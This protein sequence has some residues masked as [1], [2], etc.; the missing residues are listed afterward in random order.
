MKNDHTRTQIN[1]ANEQGDTLSILS[2]FADDAGLY[3]AALNGEGALVRANRLCTELLD[4]EGTSPIGQSIHPDLIPDES[5]ALLKTVLTDNTPRS[6]RTF[7]HTESGGRRT[8]SWHT[9]PFSSDNDPNTA[10]VL[11]GTEITTTTTSSNADT[12]NETGQRA[13]ETLLGLLRY[14]A[15]RISDSIIIT[16]INHTIIY[17]NQATEMLFGH[18][19]SELLNRK[20]DFLNAELLGNV[21][22]Q[23]IYDN[24][25]A[26]HEWSGSVRN[27]RKDGS[28]FICEMKISPITNDDGAVIAYM[29]IQRNVTDDREARNALKQSEEKYRS[30]LENI[31][32]GYYEVDLGGNFTFFNDSMS[33]ILGYSLDDMI[34]MNNRTFMSAETARK[35]FETFNQV[36]RTSQ[37]V[38]A[39]DW[40]LIRKDKEKRFVEV[41]VSLL[42]DSKNQ[43]IGFSGIA[44][45]ITERKRLE[46]QLLEAQ[47]MEAIGTLAGGIAHDFNNI[48][49]SILGFASYLKTKSC[50]DDDLHKGLSVIEESAIRA[51][52]LTA[53]LLAYSRKGI[54]TIKSLNLNRIVKEVCESTTKGIDKSIA[55]LFD[56]Q[57]DL[58]NIRGDES[59]I[60]QVVMN[61]VINARDAMPDGGKLTIKT[62]SF[63]TDSQISMPGGPLNPGEYVLLTISDTGKGMS[64]ETLTRMFEP[65]FTTK[66][67]QDGAGLG[68]SVVYGIVKSHGGNIHVES[69]PGIGTQIKVYLP[70]THELE[71]RTKRPDPSWQG[72]SET[73]LVVDDEDSIVSML[74]QVLTNAGYSVMSTQ[75]GREGLRLYE[76]NI[77][78]IDLVILDIIMP[79]LRGDE[80]LVR[81]LELN[82]S[83]RV[84]LAS[85]YSDKESY[86]H[87]LNHGTVEFI[88]KPFTIESL[89]GLIRSIL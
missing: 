44:R 49:A 76:E 56:G 87:L 48:L 86:R 46:E 40:E 84:I 33:E 65:Y 3:F 21:I 74:T 43:P 61:L 9:A 80:A 10:L 68:M 73:I 42:Q 63:I 25:S 31:N 20:P 78:D 39:F 26:G 5:G 14:V 32:D 59:Q 8:V 54:V 35:V 85:G 19:A 30:I 50:L 62:E 38:K 47:K 13:T 71:E 4:T 12:P 7:I 57:S 15:A 70:A 69:T 17:A 34:G 67:K 23:Q 83:V 75:S 36:F 55:C 72:G 77:D 16:D 82:P 22:Q 37:T 89:L 52:G 6:I 29:G 53:Q 27:R 28:E 41:S 64:E 45:D 18:P 88:G 60:H 1:T 58:K 66:V 24:L 11:L 79:D 2:R 51:S 81:I